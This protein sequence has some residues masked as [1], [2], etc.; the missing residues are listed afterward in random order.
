MRKPA[1]VSLLCLVGICALGLMVRAQHGNTEWWASNGGRKASDQTLLGAAATGSSIAKVSDNERKASVVHGFARLPMAFEPNLGQSNKQAKYVARGEGYTL[2]LTP[3]EAVLALGGG[4]TVKRCDRLPDGI[5]SAECR[6]AGELRL[7]LVG[8]NPEPGFVP[9]DELPGKSNYLISR[10]PANWHVNVPNYRKV[11]ERGVYSGIDLVYYGTQQQLEYDFVV[12]PGADPRAIG[13]AIEGSKKLRIDAQGEVV[14]SLDDG[15]VR[16]KKPVAYQEADGGKQTVTA[17]Y[18]MRRD[19]RVAFRLGE[20]DPSH[21][22]VIDPILSYS[23]YLGGSNIDGANAIAVAPDKTAF[24]TGGT[25]SLDFPTAHP[26]QPNHGGPDDFDRDAFVAKLSADGSTLLYSTYLGGKNEDAGNGIAVDAFGDAYVT[27]TTLSPDF[28]VTPG[29]FNTLCGGDG[30][31]GASFNPN[32]LIVSNAFVT[33]LNPEGSALIYS[34]FLGEYEN[35]KGQA[36]AVDANEIAYVTGQV[37]PNGVPTVPIVPPNTP[38]PPFPI[39]GSA[40][41]P[42]FGGGATDVFVS[43]IS[44]AGSQIQYSSYLGGSDEEIGYGIAAD[45][46]SNLYVTGLTYSSNLPTVNP[47]QPT[48]GGAGDGFFAKVNTNAPGP[49]SLAYSTFLGGSNLDQGNGIAVDGTGIAYIT[50]VAGTGALPFST[51]SICGNGVAAGPC[52]GTADAFV[53]KMDATKTGAASLLYFTYFGGS[54]ADTGNGI[55]VDSSGNAYVTGL[56][57]STDFPITAAVFQP[58]YGGGNAD[59]FVAQIGPSGSTLVYSSY[60]GG[61]NT[62]TGLG[63]AVDS[64]SATT[65]AAY[66]A[67]QTCSQDFPLANPLQAAPGG[68]CDAFISKVEILAGL[69]MNPGGLVFNGQSLNTT[70]QPQIVTVTN[71][72]VPETL[73]SITITGANPG[74]FTQTSAC[75]SSLAPGAQCTISV[76]FTPQ[77]SGIRKAQVNVPCPTC[78]T[79]G[80]TYVLNLSGT[81]S[82]LTLSAA[83]LA[84]GQQQ[85]GVAGTAQSITATNN[86]TVPITFT[87]ITA[88]GDFAE[89]DNCTKVSLQPT[90]NCVISVTYSPTTA[91]SSVG[92]L[93]LTDNAPGSPQVVLLT[94]T[95]FGQQSDF[96]FSAAPTSAEVP[97]GK[98]AQFKLTISPVGGFAQPITLS[99][100]G[101]P[102]ATSCSAT[103]NPVTPSG[104]TTVTVTVNTGLR[105]LVPSGRPMN[106]EPPRAMR[107]ANSWLALLVALLLITTF[108][109]LRG[110]RNPAA[111]GLVVAIVVILLSV[112]CNGGGQASSPNGTPAGTYQI[113]ITGTSGTLSHT[114]TVTLQVK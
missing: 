54:L 9:V 101:L 21:T 95:G 69:E 20:Y 90:T 72:D 102:K 67:G 109:S 96:T 92:A 40:F 23:T 104:T 105:T 5:A 114:A 84:F 28:P 62:D 36:I 48:Y 52:G 83:N 80:I 87:S 42:A 51:A 112:A 108:F 14:A 66:I 25:F 77:A 46:N 8:A 79:S 60:L 12:S 65:G 2:F 75:G 30:Q 111:A 82:T 94:G 31:C 103:A 33:K 47:L 53:A 110:S 81:T 91:G 29:S 76:T 56:T 39:T 38:P 88:S 99:C 13:I 11:A 7:R 26:L 74:D 93:T 61:T 35:V 27:G 57:V 73:G 64:A 59:A 1:I 89:T 32:H 43:K 18:V 45:G 41:Q 71:G 58:K 68:N 37:G 10:D 113:G 86:G 63:I 97:A 49:S 100:N 85:V 4:R 16:L 17:N 70:S 19:G 34:G 24:I 98:F 6:A 106:V 44:S 15:D 55:A 78:G 107:I 22:L 50:G 3:A